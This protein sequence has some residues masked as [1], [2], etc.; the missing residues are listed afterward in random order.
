VLTVSDDGPGF[1]PVILQKGATP[2][3]RDDLTGNQEH[4]GMGLYVCRMLCEKHGGNLTLNNI[5]NG[6]K[7]VAEF[8]F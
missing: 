3:L 7:A 2:F 4:F 1:S 8:C 5:A 6:A